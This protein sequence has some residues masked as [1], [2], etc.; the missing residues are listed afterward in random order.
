MLGRRMA[1]HP[2]FFR[3]GGPGDKIH[4]GMSNTVEMAEGGAGLRLGDVV[5]SFIASPS[6]LLPFQPAGHCLHQCDHWSSSDCTGTQVSH[7]SKKLFCL[8]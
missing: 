4:S 6:C 2:H 3:L 1:T 7:K 8:S 5:E